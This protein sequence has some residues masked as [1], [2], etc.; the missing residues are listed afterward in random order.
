MPRAKMKR[1]SLSVLR[2]IVS[3]ALTYT[4]QLLHDRECTIVDTF[5]FVSHWYTVDL[6]A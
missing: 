3:I 1:I 2:L 5:N 6:A 4:V